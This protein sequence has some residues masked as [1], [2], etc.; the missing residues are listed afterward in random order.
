MLPIVSTS[1]SG[2]NVSIHNINNMN[3]DW[4]LLITQKIVQAFN[5]LNEIKIHAAFNIKHNAPVLK[6][7]PYY[8]KVGG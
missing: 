1:E 2:S 6:H 7:E 4:S 5:K 3:L 8:L